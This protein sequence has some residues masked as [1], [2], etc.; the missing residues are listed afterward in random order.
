MKNLI[1]AVVFIIVHNFSLEAQTNPA[2]TSSTHVRQM[3]I[4]TPWQGD[5]KG[6]GIMNRN[7]QQQKFQIDERITMKLG[8][9]ILT[10]EGVGKDTGG[11]NAK[12][13]HHAYGVLNYDSPTGKYNFR[14]YLADGKST[15]AWFEVINHSKYQ[16]GFNVPSGKV[17][18]TIVIDANAGTWQETG[19]YSG[20]GNNWF[21]FLTMHLAKEK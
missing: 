2:D 9:S 3:E 20:D 6:E 18:Y 12:I 21:Q 5:W 16:W 1:I 7:G 17:R 8:G 4:F 13:V 10:V 11:A 15:N 14:S 19:E